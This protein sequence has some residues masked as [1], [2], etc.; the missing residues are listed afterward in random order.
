[1]D[2]QKPKFVDL[3]LDLLDNWELSSQCVAV[4]SCGNN[5]FVSLGCEEFLPELT[6]AKP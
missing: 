1:M 3:K 4:C 5:L 2:L 6:E